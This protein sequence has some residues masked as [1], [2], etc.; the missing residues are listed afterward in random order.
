MEIQSLLRAIDLSMYLDQSIDEITCLQSGTL[1]KR[2]HIKKRIEVKTL[3]ED[4]FLF[5]SVT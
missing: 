4:V 3:E 5:P 2:I 1:Q